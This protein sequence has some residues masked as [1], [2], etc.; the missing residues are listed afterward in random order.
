[1]LLNA[2]LAAGMIHPGPDA[3]PPYAYLFLVF[4]LTVW[5]APLVMA[6]ATLF[7]GQ[8]MFSDR[9]PLGALGRRFLA[10]LP[11]CS[12]TRSCGGG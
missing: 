12:S 4:L 2:W 5:E 9:A 7:L 6:P 11:S 8:S 3:S 10:S 1:M